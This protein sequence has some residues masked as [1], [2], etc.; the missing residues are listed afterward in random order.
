MEE[1]LGGTSRGRRSS[2]PRLQRVHPYTLVP[3]AARW[4]V[5]ARNIRT[6]VVTVMTGGHFDD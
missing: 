1:W 6:A 4:G 3:T 2:I 5:L